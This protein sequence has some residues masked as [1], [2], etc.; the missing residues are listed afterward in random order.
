MRT[1]LAREQLKRVI[2]SL[3]ANRPLVHVPPAE[4]TEAAR[5]S[6]DRRARWTNAAPAAWTARRLATCSAC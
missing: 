4:P 5:T 2:G 3:T 6:A 1:P